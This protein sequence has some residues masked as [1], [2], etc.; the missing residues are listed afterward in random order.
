MLL[1]EGIGGVLMAIKPVGGYTTE[2]VTYGQSVIGPTVTFPAKSTLTAL[3]PV[4]I[5]HPAEGRRLSWPVA[6]YIPRQY[7]SERSPI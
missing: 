6:D 5:S 3:W 7:T 2:H 4:L 1:Q